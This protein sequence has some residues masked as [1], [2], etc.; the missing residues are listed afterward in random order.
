MK[1]FWDRC[2]Q[3]GALYQALKVGKAVRFRT[4][5]NK[6]KIYTDAEVN[7]ILGGPT[8]VG[9]IF[10]DGAGKSCWPFTSVR[11]V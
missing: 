10:K 1:E 2:D 7:L 5:L 9:R 8:G 3:S 6:P 4:I 11:T